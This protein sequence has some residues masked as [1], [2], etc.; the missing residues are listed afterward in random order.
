MT[1]F[2]C[3]GQKNKNNNKQLPKKLTCGEK[4]VHVALF[5][6][7]GT[8]EEVGV[9]AGNRFHL[10]SFAFV[11]VQSQA[12]EFLSRVM[13]Q[14]LQSNVVIFLPPKKWKTQLQV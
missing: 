12:V 3:L 9:H 8:D 2:F 7:A 14:R 6:R 13:A 1:Q 5:L 10:A 4:D 11:I